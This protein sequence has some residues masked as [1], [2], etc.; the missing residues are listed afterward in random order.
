MYISGVGWGELTGEDILLLEGDTLG[1]PGALDSV[2]I[3]L[4]L[5]GDCSTKQDRVAGCNINLVVGDGD[6]VVDEVADGLDLD[7]QGVNC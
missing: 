6:R 2:V 4:S 5:S 1:S 7:L 3:L